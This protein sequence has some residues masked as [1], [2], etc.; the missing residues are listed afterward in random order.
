MITVET[1]EIPIPCFW[2]KKKFL[3][4]ELIRCCFTKWKKTKPY[5]PWNSFSASP[6]LQECQLVYWDQY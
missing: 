1:Y 2:S 3:K 4:I 6:R 5:V